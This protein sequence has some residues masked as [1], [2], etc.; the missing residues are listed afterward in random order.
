[1]NDQTINAYVLAAVVTVI[2][3]LLAVVISSVIK[4]ELS[5]NPQ[6]KKKRRVWFWILG[7]LTPVVVFLVGYFIMGTE[8]QIPMKSAREAFRTA[9]GIASGC[10]FVVY[11]IV[12]FVLSKIF[13]NS[14]IGH[15]F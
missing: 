7:V 12:G 11:V 6:D 14:K 3:M 4:F 5:Q 15:W 8:K 13:K 9:V 2:F 10:S 1:M